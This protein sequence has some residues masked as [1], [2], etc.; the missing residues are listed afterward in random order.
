MQYWIWDYV[1]ATIYMYILNLILIQFIQK[2]LLF[3]I[4]SLVSQSIFLKFI[5]K[6]RACP[7]LHFVLLWRQPVLAFCPLLGLLLF[8]PTRPSPSPQG[9]L[10]PPL[11]FSRWGHPDSRCSARLSAHVSSSTS[12]VTY[13]RVSWS[14]P[15]LIVKPSPVSFMPLLQVT[16]SP[17]ILGIQDI[18]KIQP[19]TI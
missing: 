7:S 17:E 19:W 9:V 2:T 12:S 16:C 14:V 8:P 10:T 15:F 6:A 18:L 13:A 1:E 5:N 3:S 11:P 4:P